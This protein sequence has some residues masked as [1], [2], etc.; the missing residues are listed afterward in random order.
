MEKNQ[1]IEILNTTNGVSENINS[2][3]II[4]FIE[5]NDIDVFITIPYEINEIFFEAKNKHGKL[6]VK[7]WMDFYGN[8]S[9]DDYRETLLD[10]SDVIKHPKLR[11]INNGKTVEAFGFDWYYFFGEFNNI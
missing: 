2:T 5:S 7:D 11:V 10:I 6:L 4:V 3:A 8:S 9:L 1:I